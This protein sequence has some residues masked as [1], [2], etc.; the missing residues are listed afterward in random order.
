MGKCTHEVRKQYWKNIISQCLKRPEGMTARQ[1][2]D[3]IKCGL[4]L[5]QCAV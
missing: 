4:R 5:P 3:E 2:L 1:W